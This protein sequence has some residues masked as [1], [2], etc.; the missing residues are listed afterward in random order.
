[1]SM[2]FIDFFDCY[3]VVFYMDYYEKNLVKTF[4]L[5]HIIVATLYF[6]FIDDD[7]SQF[8]RKIAE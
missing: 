2:I 1:M 4:R 3:M 6:S 8:I 7:K 5:D